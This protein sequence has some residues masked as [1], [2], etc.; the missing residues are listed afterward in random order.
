MPIEIK[1]SHNIITEAAKKVRDLSHNLVSSVLLKF[2]LKAALL[3]FSEK[4][5][6]SSIQVNVTVGDVARYEEKFEVRVYNIIQ[7]LNL[8]IKLIIV[9][10]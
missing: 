9:V 7:E 2:G 5:S 8:Q 4:Y 1:K 10:M 3:D 6:N